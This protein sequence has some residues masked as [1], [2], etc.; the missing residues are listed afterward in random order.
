MEGIEAHK[1]AQK[2]IFLSIKYVRNLFFNKLFTVDIGLYI[3]Y[4]EFEQFEE[5]CENNIYTVGT[6]SECR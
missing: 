5:V 3:G 1:Y 4:T 6:D 2:I